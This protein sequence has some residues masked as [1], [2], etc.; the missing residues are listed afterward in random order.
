MFSSET[1][2]TLSQLPLPAK[3]V[4]STFLISV[5]LGYCTALVQLHFQH[6]SPG[7]F[8]PGPEVPPE[9]YHGKVPDGQPEPERPMSKMEA[10]VA[11]PT[12]ARWPSE[13]MSPAFYERSGSSWDRAIKQRGEAEVRAERDTERAALIAWINSG[14]KRKEYYENDDFPLPEELREK[15]LTEDFLGEEEGH[16]AIQYLISE[17]CLR[18]HTEGG[19]GVYPLET[20]DDIAKYL[21]VPEVSSDGTMVSPRRMSLEKLA[22]STHAH[23]LSFSMLFGLTGLAFAFTSYPFVL[24][25]VL[26]PL[27]LVVQMIDISCWWLARMEAPM[28][29]YFANLILITGGIV[30]MGLVAQI[31]LSLFSMY[32]TVGKVVLTVICLATLSVIGVIYS[33][34]IV[35][36]LERE[37]ASLE[38][39][40]SVA[41]EKPNDEEAEANPDE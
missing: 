9:I 17:R 37:R 29:L 7:D 5:G 38:A 11:A 10:L 24:R 6:A 19:E 21:K 36:H 30:A 40:S 28:G 25:V 13:T 20:Y 16:I 14:E 15:P 27:V 1:R 32:R 35:P 33:N 2:P 41:E 8:F 34:V 3:L 12:G 4:I 39:E 23:W 31:L 18:C 26:A 22:Q